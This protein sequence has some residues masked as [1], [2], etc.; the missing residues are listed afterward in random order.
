MNAAVLYGPRDLRIEER[1]RPTVGA[2]DV[3]I[4]IAYCG[5]CGSDLHAYDGLRTSA[6]RRPPGPRVLGHELS[7][8]VVETGSE[9]TAWRNGDRVTCIPWTTCGSCAYCR[10]GLV[11]H[12][13]RKRLISGALAEYVVAP[14]A[15]LYRVPDHVSLDRAALAEPLSCAVWA[16]DLARI[17]SGST[18]VIIGA[19]A[20]GLLLVLLCRAGGAARVVVS[21]P[22]PVR[23][24]LA[25]DLGA[26]VTVNP[27]E[28]DLRGAVED[29]TDGLGADVAFE[30][31]GGAATAVDALAAV[32]N[33]GTVVLVGVADA[34]ATLPLAPF[35][36]YKR[37][38]TIH[39]CFTRRH[40]FPRAVAWLDV[41]NLD[42]LLGRE[43]PLS[44]A[45]HAIEWS[46]AGRG[47]KALVRP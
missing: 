27:R 38:L 29:A 35:E 14:Q 18:V 28:H 43:F 17:A 45:T 37:E 33:A 23:R 12:C 47:A 9:V 21:E 5:I 2:D 25:A 8:A 22:N 36:V 15:A 20:I 40:T 7:G 46:R 32:R 34:A 6:H 11:N 4:R 19:G 16:T 1:E 26:T 44:E 3:L 24:R 13:E 42:P 39:G 10:R 30:A 41:L 31:V